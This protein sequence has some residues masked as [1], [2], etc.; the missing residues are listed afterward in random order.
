MLKRLV[1]RP[2]EA[3][4]KAEKA[5]LEAKYKAE[6]ESLEDVNYASFKD[7]FDEAIA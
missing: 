7:G 4:L 6:V 2:R 5:V 1:S 3:S